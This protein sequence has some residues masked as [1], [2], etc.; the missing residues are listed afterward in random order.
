M[1]ITEYKNINKVLPDLNKNDEIAIVSCDA[2]AKAC[3]NGGEKGISDIKKILENFGY[4][5]V[6]EFVYG[7]LCD[8]ELDKNL[9]EIKGNVVLVLG[10]EAGEYNFKKFTN[11][12]TIL[13]L[14]SLGLGAYD[15]ENK[16]FII[17][18]F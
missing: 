12:K 16:P 15:E 9:R 14:N 1:I 10:C 5:V 18:S 2:C 6:D 13:C 4:N 7:P 17:K 11:K 3:G 8:K